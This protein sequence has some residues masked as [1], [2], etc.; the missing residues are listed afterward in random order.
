M[1]IITIGRSSSN[2]VCVDD[3]LVSRTHCRIYQDDSGEFGLVDMNSKNGTYVNGIKVRGHVTLRRT[4]VVRIGNTT[5]PW[6]TY[7]FT[8]AEETTVCEPVV[9]AMPYERGGCPDSPSSPDIVPASGVRPSGLGTVALILSI[10]GAGLLIYC[11]VKIM[12][13]GLFAFLGDTQAY[14]FVSVG[15]NVLAYILGAVACEKEY[16]DEEAAEIGKWIAGCCL[17][18]V[19]AFFL[20][21][22]FGNA[23]IL[24]PFVFR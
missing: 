1:K 14:I 9:D 22:K 23:G 6:Q 3:M 19:A 17:F 4:D 2:D 21:L 18:V 20:Y 10:A 11:A 13:W 24:N 16:K 7:F 12:N 15:L 8:P 5:L